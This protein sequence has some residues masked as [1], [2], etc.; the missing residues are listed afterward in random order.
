MKSKKAEEIIDNA[1]TSVAGTLWKDD[2]IEAIEIAEQETEERIRHKAEIAFY[3]NCN[4]CDGDGGCK[5]SKV[6]C[7][8][9]C[10]TAKRFIQ[11]LNK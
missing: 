9:D 10:K 8:M 4:F 6:V 1:W 11:A 5:R 3:H 2:A 7:K